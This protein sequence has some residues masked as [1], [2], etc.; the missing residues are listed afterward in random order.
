VGVLCKVFS[1]KRDSLENL[2][3]VCELKMGDITLSVGD[4]QSRKGWSTAKCSTVGSVFVDYYL[5][6]RTTITTLLLQYCTS[7]I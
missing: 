2:T 5:Q 6:E 7:L 3:F 1:A 4:K